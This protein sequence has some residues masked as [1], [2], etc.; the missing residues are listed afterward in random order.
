MRRMTKQELHEWW[1]NPDTLYYEWWRNLDPSYSVSSR[2]SG[3][4][5]ARSDQPV[6]SFEST[7]EKETHMARNKAQAY[8]V[9]IVKHEHINPMDGQVINEEEILYNKVVIGCPESPYS[10]IAVATLEM[11]ETHEMT[12]AGLKK[13]RPLLGF[14]ITPKM[15]GC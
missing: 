4:H 6:P 5:V 13:I 9:M 10:A 1:C 2:Y 12:A 8:E 14:A 15:V 11:A 3:G 7:T